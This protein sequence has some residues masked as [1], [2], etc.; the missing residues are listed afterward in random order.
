MRRISTGSS[1]RAALENEE[2]IA[3]GDTTA[4]PAEPAVDSLETELLEVQDSAAEGETQEGQVEQAVEVAEALEHYRGALESIIGNGGLDRNGAH[5]MAVGLEREYARG[6]FT[7]EEMALPAMES[8]G[9]TSSRVH[10]TQLALEDIKSKAKEIWDQIVKAIKRA[11]EWVVG[12]FNKV[13]GA[14]EKL[15]KRAEAVAKAADGVTSKPKETKVENASVFKALQV[16]GAVNGL[17]KSMSQVAEF[18]KTGL[19]AGPSA[20]LAEGDALVAAI[21]DPLNGG[22]VE[23]LKISGVKSGSGLSA[24]PEADGFAKQGNGIT[25][26]RSNELPGG[27]ALVVRGPSA[28]VSGVKALEVIGKTR[29]GIEAFKPNAK[30]VD[31]AELP[32]LAPSD[33]ETIAKAVGVIAGEVKAYRATNAKLQELL[34]KASAA[35]EKAGKT[36]TDKAEDREVLN[37]VRKAGA[38]F[39]SFVMAG[40]KSVSE[41]GLFTGKSA[42]DY[43]DLSLKQYS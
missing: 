13:F 14:A 6:G 29:S 15:E 28:D 38:G 36:D 39:V 42:L 22:A 37:A 2:V 43:C 34:K 41:Y 17:A 19:T 20:I 7:K 12:H 9:T 1:L 5:I 10:S 3:A 35:A 21:A 40:S 32:V 30:P 25:L 16:N 26:L 4:V 24:A 23:K 31:K 33:I 27:K 18:V 8:F 11:I